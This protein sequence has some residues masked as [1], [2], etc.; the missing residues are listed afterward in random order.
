[1]C[2]LFTIVVRTVRPGSLDGL[3]MTSMYYW[4]QK[5]CIQNFNGGN[6]WR[7]SATKFG[8]GVNHWY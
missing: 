5:K 2:R 7:N 1:M 4:G 8:G 6:H 3:Y